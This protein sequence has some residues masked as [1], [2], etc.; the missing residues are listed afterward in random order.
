MKESSL[1]NLHEELL[2]A[3]ID[4]S[5]MI[6]GNRLLSDFSFNE[7]VICR[8]LYA[9]RQSGGRPVTATELCSRMQLLKSQVNRILTSME[10]AGIIQRVRS[11]QDKRKIEIQL[12]EE[13][14]QAYEREHERILRLMAY[15][16]QRMGGE[17]CAML[18]HLLKEAVA[19][20]QELP[21]SNEKG[22]NE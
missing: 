8:I 22:T 7:M 13:A 9:Q 2:Q 6:R 16:G 1:L 15:I 5:L 3:W 18:A 11:V 21:A 19:S 17:Q 12:C 4:M 10:K 14:V 20:I